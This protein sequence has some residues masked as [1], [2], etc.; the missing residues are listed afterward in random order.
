MCLCVCASVCVCMRVCVLV[1]VCM[2]VY[3]C[4]FTGQ[5]SQT[6]QLGYNCL[7][8]ESALCVSLCLVNSVNVNFSTYANTC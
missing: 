6:Y 1:C 8:A 5:P 4:V 7:F 2:C 3:V